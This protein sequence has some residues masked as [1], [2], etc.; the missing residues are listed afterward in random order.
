MS[1]K[2]TGKNYSNFDDKRPTDTARILLRTCVVGV[3]YQYR[4]YSPSIYMIAIGHI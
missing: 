2:N 1:V 4:R 3:L